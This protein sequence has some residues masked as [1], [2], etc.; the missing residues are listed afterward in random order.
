MRVILTQN[1]PKLGEVGEVRDVSAGYGRNYLLPQGMAIL[2][3]RGALKQ[4]DDLQR[5]ERRRQAMM[6]SSVEAQADR[7]AK[8]RL[9]FTAKVGQTGRLYGSI[10]SSDIAQQ[11]QERLGEDV[12]RRKIVLDEPIKALGEH[13]VALHLMPGVNAKVHLVVNADEEILED[14]SIEEAEGVG[15][16]EGAGASG[17]EDTTSAVSSEAA[18]LG[19]EAGAED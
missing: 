13:D 16:E 9:E 18:E 6:R 19:E 8:V 3:T 17:D 15:D 12:D 11:L 5:T 4:I 14:V 7:I 2:A 1:V 10:T